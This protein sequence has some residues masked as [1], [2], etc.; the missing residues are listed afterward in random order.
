MP[1]IKLFLEYLKCPVGFLMN[2]HIDNY[3]CYFNNV[4]NFPDPNNR[5]EFIGSKCFN[6]VNNILNMN[7]KRV[8]WNTIEYN[9]DLPSSN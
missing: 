6:K 3:S 8:N 4:I 7:N 1:F 9:F 5:N 2:E